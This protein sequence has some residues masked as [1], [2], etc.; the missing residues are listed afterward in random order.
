MKLSILVYP[1][2]RKSFKI[3]FPLFE[4]MQCCYRLN[5]YSV[6]DINTIY[7]ENIQSLYNTAN[8]ATTLMNNKLNSRVN[9]RYVKL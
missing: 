8:T 6:H 3:K 1:W 7:K 2:S 4:G 5:I 9:H